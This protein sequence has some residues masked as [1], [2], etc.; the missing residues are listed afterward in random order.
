MRYME[1]VGEEGVNA[2]VIGFEGSLKPRG[3]GCVGHEPGTWLRAP[4]A[5]PSL[6][7]LPSGPRWHPIRGVD[8][9]YLD[10]H[11]MCQSLEHHS[12][13]VIGFIYLPC[14]VHINTWTW[15]PG[16]KWRLDYFSIMAF[17]S[18]W[19]PISLV[20]FSTMVL[21]LSMKPYYMVVHSYNKY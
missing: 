11:D 1:S 4:L 20:Y 15:D 12:Q 6:R 13:L 18:P 9:S 17:N 8:G 5:T 14:G 3:D 2:P 7:P 10:P 16:L 19:D 21:H